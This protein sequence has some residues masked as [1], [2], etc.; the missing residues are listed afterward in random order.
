M[1]D[2]CCAMFLS[3]V[4]P[5]VVYVKYHTELWTLVRLARPRLTLKVRLSLVYI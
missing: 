5:L 4:T 3:C 1:F 2:I